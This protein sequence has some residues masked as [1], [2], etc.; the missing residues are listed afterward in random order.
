MARHETKAT[1]FLLVIDQP[2]AV[3]GGGEWHVSLD[4]LLEFGETLKIGY[5]EVH[6]DDPYL[7]A[8]DKQ[9]RFCP[10]KGTCEELARWSLEQMRLSWDDLDGDELHLSEIGAFTAAHRAALADNSDLIGKWLAGVHGK[11]LH[12]AIAG[13]PTPGL[14]AVR[15]RKGPRQWADDKKATKFLHKHLS[16]PDEA[17]APKKLITTTQAEKKIP[18][19]K[20]AAQDG[21]TCQSE[22]K[23]ILVNEDDKRPAINMADEWDDDDVDDLPG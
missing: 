8:G 23:P 13:Q 7:K 1:E 22:G 17:F 19:D 6:A 3:G 16:G 5:A 12:D 10:V 4:E 14:K 2:R 15:G 21:L 20:W 18:A 11:V 9:C